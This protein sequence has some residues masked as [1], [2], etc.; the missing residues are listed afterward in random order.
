VTAR[1]RLAGPLCVA[2]SALCFGAMPLFARLA[3]ADGV[4]TPTLLLLRFSIA[5][6]ILWA[7]LLARDVPPPRG[8]ALATLAAMGAIGYAGQAFCYFHALTLASAGL[9]ALL[10]YT[11]PA[12][13]TLLSRLV[14]GHPLSRLQLFAVAMA[15]GGSALTV[16]GAADGTPGGVL[17]ALGAAAIYSVYIVVGS[18]LPATVTPAASSAVILASAALVYAG[19]AVA[20]GVRLP[21]TPAGWAGVLGVALV[22]SVFAIGLFFAGLAR[23]GPVRTSIYST[24]EPAFT[25]ALAAAFLGERVAPARVAGGALILGAVLV[26]ARADARNAPADVRGGDR[27]ERERR[28]P[29]P[30]ASSEGGGRP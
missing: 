29:R 15:L 3:A 21:S 5:G 19:A 26:L 9:V 25:V 20:R 14:L 24:L 8:R 22:G 23:I 27:A 7:V 28:A 16:G 1:R 18:R 30:R 11:F 6:A 12:I 2:A 13:V 17:F 10:L 4:D